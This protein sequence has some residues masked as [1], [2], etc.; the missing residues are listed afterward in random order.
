MGRCT[1]HLGRYVPFDPIPCFSAFGVCSSFGPNRVFYTITP[2]IVYRVMGPKRGCR[3]RHRNVD[4]NS[5]CEEDGVLLP[6]SEL[7]NALRAERARAA[8]AASAEYR[9]R[10]AVLAGVSSH[11]HASR[12]R[13]DV[14]VDGRAA[15]AGVDGA[16]DVRGGNVLVLAIC[17]AR[18]DDGVNPAVD[19][20]GGDA[21]FVLGVTGL[22]AGVDGAVEPGGG[23]ADFDC[24]T[25]LGLGLDAGV[26]GAVERGGDEQHCIHCGSPWAR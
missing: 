8:R 22:D 24:W 13:A 12:V 25:L 23:D 20:G 10:R 16:V 17:D 14:A 7:A 5:E 4:T 1:A 26:D 21:H 3:K 11:G 18:L 6:P 15:S 19:G 2:F 9:K